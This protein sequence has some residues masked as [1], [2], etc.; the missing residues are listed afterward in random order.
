MELTSVESVQ[1]A[2]AEQRYLADRA[3]STAVFRA[4]EL[5]QPLL[6][7]GEAGVGKTE[8]GKALAAVLDTPLVR[9]QCYDGIDSK[10]NR[11]RPA[12]APA[13][14]ARVPDGACTPATR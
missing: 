6:L 11:L 7:E 8:A 3:L 12:R 10:V 14:T 2:L 5:A 1:A 9:L 4:A 13:G